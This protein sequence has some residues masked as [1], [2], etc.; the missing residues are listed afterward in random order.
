MRAGTASK[1]PT[2]PDRL[3][4]PSDAAHTP[5]AEFEV[6][7]LD[8]PARGASSAEDERHGGPTVER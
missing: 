7:E 4:P 1:P 6:D 5:A 8:V 3:P 2:R